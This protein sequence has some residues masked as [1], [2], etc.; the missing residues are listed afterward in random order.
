MFE[1]RTRWMVG[2]VIAVVAAIV[3]VGAVSVW[4]T[5]TEFAVKSVA[6]Q[7]FQG[8][9]AAGADEFIDPALL[10]DL[11]LI[12]QIGEGELFTESGVYRCDWAVR[13]TVPWARIEVFS[14][15]GTPQC[16]SGDAAQFGRELGR[17]APSVRSVA[18]FSEP[19]DAVGGHVIRVDFVEVN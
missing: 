19:A 3:T 13:R 16:V 15:E 1:V 7:Q 10:I 9:L 5:V 17:M 18:L 14:V 4:P 6:E 11:P 12:V 8:A 2:A